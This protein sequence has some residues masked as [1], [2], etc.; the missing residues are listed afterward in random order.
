MEKLNTWL[1]LLANFGVLIGI[2]FLALEIQQNNNLLERDIALSQQDVSNGQFINSDYLPGILNKIN[3][4]TGFS[5][6]NQQYID[7]F[8]L[9]PEE[10]TR[11][12]RYINQIWR[13]NEANWQ[14]LGRTDEICR[15]MAGSLGR[16][17]DHVICWEAR[18]EA[19][20]PDF[21]ACIEAAR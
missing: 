19:Y 10:A 21:V 4:A 9:T 12:A 14:A 18:R 13:E 17:R 6:F 7:E 16:A 1:T 20:N 3:D 2:I 8:D 15:S 5:G 11:W